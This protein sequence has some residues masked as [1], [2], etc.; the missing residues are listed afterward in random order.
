MDLQKL[1]NPRKLL[2]L[3][4]INQM[5]NFSMAAWKTKNSETIKNCDFSKCLNNRMNG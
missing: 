4:V 2:L 1:L 3:K 5:K